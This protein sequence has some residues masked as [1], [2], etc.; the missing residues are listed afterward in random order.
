MK[1]FL[2]LKLLPVSAIYT[3]SSS[4]ARDSQ[5]VLSALEIKIDPKFSPSRD[6]LCN[7]LLLPLSL[8]VYIKL[9]WEAK[10]DVSLIIVLSLDMFFISS[11]ALYESVIQNVVINKMQI[12]W[13]NRFTESIKFFI[14]RNSSTFDYLHEQFTIGQ[15]VGIKRH[16]NLWLAVFKSPHLPSIGKYSLFQ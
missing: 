12:L 3:K 13:L 9:L 5:S 10:P 14:R 15:V 16:K 2:R 4:W 7:R 8:I 6:N 11:S 1:V